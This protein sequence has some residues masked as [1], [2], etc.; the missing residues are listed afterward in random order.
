MENG[1]RKYEPKSITRDITLYRVLPNCSD[2]SDPMG[3]ITFIKN[4]LA[5]TIHDNGEMSVVAAKQCDEC[6]EWRTE[7]GGFSYRD[8]SGEVVIWLCAQCRA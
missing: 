2:G 7:L 5:T 8:V 6:Y 4:G 3:E 1:N